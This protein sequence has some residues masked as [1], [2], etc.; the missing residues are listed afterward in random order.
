[1]TLDHANGSV[2]DESS[3]PS[4]PPQPL[5]NPPTSLFGFG[6]LPGTEEEPDSPTSDPSDDPGS[7]SETEW[8]N[9]P[10]LDDSDLDD[11][12]PTSSPA[13]SA[14]KPAQLLSK[15]Q[16]R[17]TARASVKIGTG[18][19]HT[20]AAK[21][22]AQRAVGLYLADDEDAANIGDPLADLMHRRGD[23]IGGKLSPDANDFLRSLMGVAGYLT[24]QIQKI[25]I[26][27]QL[28]APAQQAA[29]VQHIPDVA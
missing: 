25:G 26:V 14:E 5:L 24:K 1:M 19:A 11:S 2:L 16:M 8:L 10:E 3:S 4:S 22:E 18:M 20:V 6:S 28:E 7:D 23:V 21:T 15:A 17:K 9:E 27:R 13:S 12:D 29:D